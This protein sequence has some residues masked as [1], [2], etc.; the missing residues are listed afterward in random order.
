MSGRD[1]LAG[2]ALAVALAACAGPAV[3]PAPAAGRVVFLRPSMDRAVYNFPIVDPEG[4][5]VA[6]VGPG[7]Q[8]VLDVAP[9]RRHWE[10]VTPDGRDALD[11]D[12][13]PGGAL[14]VLVA[15]DGEGRFR[16]RRLG[17][18]TWLA[19]L[20]S[21]GRGLSPREASFGAGEGSTR[22]VTVGCD[23]RAASDR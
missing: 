1:V 15:A 13:V 16:L 7:S 14:Y 12:L 9:G 19:E 3:A 6:L 2:L 21:A 4:N 17:S 18:G 20:K 10:L 11:A 23:A 5:V 22:L 8:T